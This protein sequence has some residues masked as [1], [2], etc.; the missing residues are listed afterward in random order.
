[1]LRIQN[2]KFY[3]TI[4]RS[5]VIG[6]FDSKETLGQQLLEICD[7]ANNELFSID[8]LKQCSYLKC[9]YL[10]MGSHGLL[11]QASRVLGLTRT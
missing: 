4:L 6:C 9:S 11:F 8:N 7:V 5:I 1:M 2:K 3:Q 10:K